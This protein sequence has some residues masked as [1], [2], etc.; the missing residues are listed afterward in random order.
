MRQRD[1][2]DSPLKDAARLWLA[3][4]IT[5]VLSAYRLA[6]HMMDWLR[7]FFVPHTQ[8]PVAD[9]ITNGLF[10]WLLLLLWVAYRRWQ[11]SV[12]LARELDMVISS[13]GPDV[14]LVIGRDRTVTMCTGAS[15]SMYGYR[16]EEIL[17]QK[18]DLLYFDRRMDRGRHEIYEDLE[19][20]GFHVGRAKGQ[21]KNGTTFPLEIVT[22]S[23]KEQP[24]AV[25]L[26]RDITDRKLLED[27]LVILSTHDELT[28]LLNRRGFFESAGQQLRFAKRHGMPMF[29][30]FADLNKFKWINDNLGHQ[31]GDEALK[32]TAAVFRTNLREADIIGR[33]GG[34]EIAVLGT[35]SKDRSGGLVVE[36]LR[37]EL[38]RFRDDKERFTLSASIG[39]AHFD[40]GNPRTLDDLVLEGD[41]LMY[42]DKQQRRT[43]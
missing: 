32:A 29:L 19:S 38:Q 8:I 21:R 13:I 7:E 37:Q 24:G 43:P 2:H 1:R 4:A 30:L 39:L 41:K 14:L 11:R 17:G 33:L 20:K 27:K 22:A 34:D 5:L 35:E 26:L 6:V 36:R 18:T 15:E 3:V 31:V 23:L 28:G 10:F 42:A 16:A 40:P 12:A 9:W 25:I